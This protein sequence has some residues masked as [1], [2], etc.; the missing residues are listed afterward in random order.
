MKHPHLIT[1]DTD[2][3]LTEIEPFKKGRAI[4][5][6]DLDGAYVLTKESLEESNKVKLFE[7]FVRDL[8]QVIEESQ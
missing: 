2:N 6:I 5:E 1:P 3:T 8:K 4:V 7:H